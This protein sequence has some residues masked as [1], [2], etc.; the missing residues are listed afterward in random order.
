MDAKVDFIE[1]AMGY[2]DLSHA[3]LKDPEGNF[4]QLWQIHIR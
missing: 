1:D 2:R 4:V 3:T